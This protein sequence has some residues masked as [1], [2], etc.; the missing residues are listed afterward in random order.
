VNAKVR[1]GVVQLSISNCI[2]L[3]LYAMMN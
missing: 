3:L 1:H 2:A